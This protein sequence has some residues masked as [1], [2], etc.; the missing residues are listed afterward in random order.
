M[1]ETIVAS[2]DSRAL[3]PRRLLVGFVIA[4]A[5]SLLFLV[6]TAYQSAATLFSRI[7]QT[8]VMQA[9]SGAA[10]SGRI[11]TDVTWFLSAQI[12]LHLALAAVAWSLAVASAVL[13]RTAREKFG[14]IV[15]GWFSLLGAATI[16]YNAYW[17][18]RTLMGAY[19]HDVVAA[20]LGGWPVA[21]LVYW[22][23]VACAVIVLVAA[24]WRSVRRAAAARS[25]GL[26]RLVAAVVVVGGGLVLWS[27]V[28][29]GLNRHAHEQRPN[30][31]ILGIDSLRLEHLR[32]FGGAG[33]TPQIDQFLADADIFRDATTP[34]ARTFSSWTAILTGRSPT[35]TG[36]RFNLA[37]RSSVAATPTLGDVL[38]AEGYKTVYSTDEVR[39]ANIDETFG[40]D[41]VITPR[42][43]A[44]DF[45]IGTYN[46]LPLASVIINTRL[47]QWLFPF[48]H[49]NRGVATMFR[50]ETYLGR[51][52]RELSFDGP[53]LFIAH[54]TAPHWP[55]YVSD[56]PFGTT[57]PNDTGEHPL[58]HVGIGTADHMFGEMIGIL[59]RKGALDNAL[60][61]ILSDHGEAFGLPG[62][63]LFRENQ[64]AFI[65]GLRAPIKM[66][67][68]GHGQSV[69]SP[70]QYKVL[71]GFRSF[72]E[73][74]GF[75][76]T[77]RDWEAPVT[78]EDIAPTI[79]ELLAVPG[80]PLEASG[81]SL[82]PILRGLGASSPG[83]SLDRIRFTETDLAVLPG[84]DGGVDEV[85]TARQNSRFFN[86]DYATGRLEISKRYEPLAVAFKERAA[87]S[88]EMLLAA[89]PAGPYAHQYLL[90]DLANGSGRLLLEEPGSE[91]PEAQ[92]LW[93]ALHANYPGE[94]QPAV[95]VTRDDWPRIDEEWRSFLQRRE[96][97]VQTGP[98]DAEKSGS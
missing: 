22:G 51:I 25:V 36:A 54:L 41:Q 1:P 23:V 93:H 11:A 28:G 84:P 44:S 96:T 95:V 57:N 35:V 21:Q 94:L 69:L 67:D 13:W 9:A 33:G 45:L 27:D 74:D 81:Q 15:V 29:A 90:F 66:N 53:T 5:L 91:Q 88:K 78:V 68:H 17:Y 19:Y 42:I 6:L 47:G 48:S 37:A 76:S 20:T 10:V 8:S 79:L 43:G 26:G 16:T 89:L 34:A 46:E 87:F 73:F 72:G 12:L 65:E 39:F 64:A 92:R 86:V 83:L 82:A 85:G 58:Y 32:R 50:P 70:S 24:S 56:T 49:A 71:L 55:Y 2:V 38:R 4:A 98:L 75:R 30:V 63:T 61:V 97:M 40:F 77:A 59:Q 18:P 31:I 3:T 14:R 62:D 52:E 60:V 7:E 80:D